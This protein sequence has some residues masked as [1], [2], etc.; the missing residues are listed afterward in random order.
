M[1]YGRLTPKQI[2]IVRRIVTG[3]EVHDLGAGNLQLSGQL[4]QLGATRVTAIDRSLPRCHESRITLVEGYFHDYREKIDVAFVSWPCNWQD[5]GL[6]RLVRE[7]P[8]VIY[9][10]KN[11]DGTMCG[12]RD[13]FDALSV[14][15]IRAYE[16]DP[17]NTLIVYGPKGVVRQPRG[18]EVAAQR[19]ERIWS[20]EEAERV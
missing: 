12:G 13:F 3:K 7:S 9:L 16:P 17:H 18:E 11:T 2:E 15:E 20:Y 10:G 1:S 6:V 8:V 19:L 14:R 4:L 5:M